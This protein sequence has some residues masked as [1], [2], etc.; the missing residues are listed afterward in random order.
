ME[1]KEILV[2]LD[3]TEQCN[4]R[5]D[6]AIALARQHGARLT[7]LHV[8]SHQ[9]FEPLQ[10]DTQSKVAM[11]QEEFTVK[12]ARAAIDAHWLA[13]DSKVLGAG[14]TEI[15]N[16][17]AHYTD[18]VVVGQTDPTDHGTPNDLP[19]RVVLGSGRPVLIVPYA[20]THPR[21]GERTMVAWAA[22]REATR[23]VNDA[24]PLLKRAHDVCVM[25]ITPPEPDSRD[26]E[27]LCAHLATHGVAARAKQILAAEVSVGDSLLNRV[28]VEGSNLLVMGAYAHVR[29]GVPALG[30]V[31][32][33]ILRHMTVP[34]LMAH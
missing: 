14:V 34:V 10:S 2:F 19:E 12:T 7:G 15:I 6:L 9:F 3:N 20:G 11:V 17:H 22:G 30:E 23:A 29:L 5:L 25:E 21:A 33:H 26:G 4:S 8:V 28:S 27:R 16:E 1:F 31:A 13:V 18:L 24:L 32:R